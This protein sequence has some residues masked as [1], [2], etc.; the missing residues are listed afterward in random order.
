MLT[1]PGHLS[2]CTPGPRSI[3]AGEVAPHS[4][5]A[6]EVETELFGGAKD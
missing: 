1:H 5:V 2:I 6:A 3:L 4:H